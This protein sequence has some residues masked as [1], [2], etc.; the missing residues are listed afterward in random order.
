M[1]NFA[2]GSYLDGTS[3][4][5]YDLFGSLVTGAYSQEWCRYV[6]D[7]GENYCASIYIINPDDININSNYFNYFPYC[8]N[9]S[10]IDL[11]EATAK[12]ASI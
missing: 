12:T 3:K 8:M 4:S 10:L 7:Y 2:A 6:D 9:S 5:Y 1:D 11:P